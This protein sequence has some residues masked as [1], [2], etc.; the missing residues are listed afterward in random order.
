[1]IFNN[2]QI[3]DILGILKRWECIF[4]G[5]QLGYNYL[6]ANEKALLLA[7][8]ID[9]NL[10]KNSQGIIDHAFYFGILSDALGSK[11][12]KG[13][14]Y[15]QFTKFLGSGNFIP[16]TE[17]ERFALEQIKNRAYNDIGGLGSRIRQ[18]TSNIIVRGN[19]KNQ[20]KIKALIKDKAAKAVELRKSGR[21]LAAELGEATK[22]WERDWLRIAYYLLHEAYN[23]GIAQS[24]VK[25]HGVDSEVYFDVYEGACKHCKEL[26]LTDPEDPNSE[27]IVYVLDDVIANGNNIGRKAADYKATIS[28][29]HP[30]C[31]C[32]INH[33][34]KGYLWDSGLRAFSIAPKY[35]AKNPRLQGVKLDIKVTK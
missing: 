26:Y 4:V 11:R 12:A 32:T 25:N 31:R 10:Y 9:V 21:T 13:L 23:S 29:V 33:K 20:F 6:S 28:P 22:D 16:L 34:Q 18:G 1:M 7:S 24:I 15:S 3:Q 27:P 19:Q 8:G 30:Y 5:K 17:Q 35:I 2:N 14:N